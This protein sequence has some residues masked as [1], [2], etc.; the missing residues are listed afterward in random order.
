[1]YPVCDCNF[2]TGSYVANAEGFLLEREEMQWFFDCY[3]DGGKHD[4][5]DPSIS[6]LRASDLRGVAPAIVITAEFDPLRDEGEAYA[7]H[8]EAAGVV[9]KATRY[10][11]LIHGFF[12]LSGAFDASRDAIELV[13]TALQRAFGTLDA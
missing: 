13:G 2:E 3:T 12:G 9:A 8:L 10:D 7:R 6:P 1:M 5:A 11:G 4:P